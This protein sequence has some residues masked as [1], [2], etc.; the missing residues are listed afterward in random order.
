[1]ITPKISVIIPTYKPQ[2]YIWE[3]LD[4]LKNQELD[5]EMFEVIIVLNG[6]RDPYES[7][8]QSYIE[9]MDGSWKLIQLNEGGVSNARNVGI[10]QSQGEFIAFIDD[11]DIVSPAYLKELLM[12]SSHD[13]VGICRPV[14]F[15]DVSG[16]EVS[17]KM[18]D[19]FDNKAKLGKQP[20]YK[21]KKLFSGPC[22]KLI[23]RHIIGERRFDKRFKNSE[24]SLFMF[25]ISNK[26]KWAAFT[27]SNA[28]YYR[29]FRSGSAVT[30]KRS[31]PDKLS[32]S[33][34]IIGEESK[35]YW[36]HFPQ[37]SFSFYF[38]R[39]LG[40]IHGALI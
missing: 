16:K 9:Q 34:K 36:R 26:I 25:T 31:F 38:T 22:M 11:D 28:V 17:I 14:A 39:M 23:H 35:L 6:C 20:F 37:Y 27:S 18:T 19:E 21:P 13:T 24:D 12:V 15:D 30:S 2:D 7:Q 29:R 32:N 5:K 3:C 4:S 1:M 33:C 10:E 8:I 40:A